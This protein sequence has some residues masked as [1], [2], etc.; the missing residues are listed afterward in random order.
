MN[1][2]PDT[3]G[4]KIDFGDINITCTTYILIETKFKELAHF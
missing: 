4:K 3:L 1:Q 2:I